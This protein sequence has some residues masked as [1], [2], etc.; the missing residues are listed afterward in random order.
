M[1]TCFTRTNTRHNRRICFKDVWILILIWRLEWWLSVSKIGIE[2]N[3]I[4]ISI[5]KNKFGIE[6]KQSRKIGCV[7]VLYGSNGSMLL[8]ARAFSAHVLSVRVCVCVLCISNVVSCVNVVLC[9]ANCLCVCV[10]LF[11][12]KSLLN[13]MLLSLECIFC[14]YFVKRK[15]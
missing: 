4:E 6:L 1:N 11:R 7:Y 14:N 5:G 15:T 9:V 12:N 13:Q 8:L 10:F 2:S 3:R